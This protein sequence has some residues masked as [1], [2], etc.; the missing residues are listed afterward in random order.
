MTM[1]PMTSQ[2]LKQLALMFDL[3]FTMCKLKFFVN[4]VHVYNQNIIAS[5]KKTTYLFKILDI[6]LSK[7][8]GKQLI[9]ILLFSLNCVFFYTQYVVASILYWG[10]GVSLW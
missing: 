4:I 8:Y 5:E 9:D 7:T 3:E 10:D 2:S 6:I 1:L